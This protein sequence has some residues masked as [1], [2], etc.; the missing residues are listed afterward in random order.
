MSQLLLD[1]GP[2]P[3]PTF[4][5]FVVGRPDL[6]DTIRRLRAFEAAGADVLFAPGL[7]DVA[8]VRE[9]C[10]AVSKPVS[11]L[12]TQAFTVAELAQAGVKRISIGPR[13]STIAFAAVERAAREMLDR[14]LRPVAGAVF[15]E[16]ACRTVAPGNCRR[17]VLRGSPGKG[18]APLCCAVRTRASKDALSCLERVAFDETPGP[19]AVFPQIQPGAF[20]RPG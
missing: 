7:S 1:L 16:P 8:Q 10:A 12:A 2:P 20:S 4:E 19:A 9:I 5:N 11:V 18:Y 3:R 14:A 6:D 17:C 15:P 13:L